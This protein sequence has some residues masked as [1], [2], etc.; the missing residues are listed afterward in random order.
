MRLR[1]DVRAAER[2]LVSRNFGKTKADLSIGKLAVVVARQGGVEPV[3]VA[4]GQAE[5]AR[6]HLEPVLGQL[7]EHRAQPFVFRS[8][9]VLH[10]LGRIIAIPLLSWV[11]WHFGIDPKFSAKPKTREENFGSR[12]GLTAAARHPGTSLHRPA[13]FIAPAP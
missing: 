4:S 5:A 9:R 11:H 10:A 12:H 8:M 1:A 7:K 3:A 2:Q 6:G 13:A